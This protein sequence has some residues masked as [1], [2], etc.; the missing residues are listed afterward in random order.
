MRE[1]TAQEKAAV[2]RELRNCYRVTGNPN[3]F[4]DEHLIETAWRI[5]RSAS[6]QKIYVTPR[7]YE[8]AS[9]A[10]LKNFSL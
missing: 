4:K 1:Y 6:K 3:L 5:M 2:R 9:S 8:T 7:P 10:Y